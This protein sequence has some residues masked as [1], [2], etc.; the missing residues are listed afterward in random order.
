MKKN[1]FL[2]L[3]LLYSTAV[4]AQENSEKNQT[5]SKTFSFFFE[6]DTFFDT[7]REYTNGIRLSLTY[8][9][10]PP[11]YSSIQN[12]MD[13]IG[14]FTGL[15]HKNSKT[16]YS[17]TLGQNIYTPENTKASEIVKDERPYSGLTYLGASIISATETKMKTL[18]LSAGM[19]GPWSLAEKTQK[20]VHEI[21]NWEDPKGWDNQLSNE[22]FLE[23]IYAQRWKTKQK[24]NNGFGVDIIPE[25]TAGV[26][27]ALVYIQTG[28]GFRAGYN[29]PN[30]FGTPRIRPA[31]DTNFP[32]DE[33]D[34]RYNPKYKRFG[35]YFFCSADAKFIPRNI[36]LDGNTFKNSH[37]V[38]KNPVTGTTTIG[39]GLII[40]RFNIIYG[41][42]FDSKVYKKQKDRQYYGTLSVS[43]TW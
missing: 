32:L 35:I 43:Y 30:D 29:I 8:A 5:P 28:V 6:N 15:T 2:I 9:N 11:D 27:N 42:V 14:K 1:F 37:S 4:F 34:P 23:L 12:F 13:K 24:M 16:A 10:L 40:H 41:H 31:T 3:L 20:T 39:I 18:E 38:K 21:C 26:G 22:P 36:F 25:M 7:D 33:T 19:I 17:L